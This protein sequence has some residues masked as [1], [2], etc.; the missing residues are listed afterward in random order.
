MLFQLLCDTIY[1]VLTGLLFWLEIPNLDAIEELQY[2]CDLAI[3]N[4]IGIFKFFVPDSVIIFGFFYVLTCEGVLAA[5]KV[6]MFI[7]RKIPMLG[8]N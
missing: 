7:L 3:S 4:G 8:I 1:D 2:I 5:Y 6:I